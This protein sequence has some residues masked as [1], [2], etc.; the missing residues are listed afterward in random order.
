M[1]LTADTAHDIRPS[2]VVCLSR[3]C[4]VFFPVEYSQKL[5]VHYKNCGCQE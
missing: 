2:T 3:F 4:P 1:R 5:S